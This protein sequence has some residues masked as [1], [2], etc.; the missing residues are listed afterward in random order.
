MQGRRKSQRGLTLVEA[1]VATALT[2]LLFLGALNLYVAAAQLA[3]STAA[4]CYAVTDGANAVQHI[5]RDA[6]EARRLA[7]PDESG[8]QPPGNMPLSAFQTADGSAVIS[9]GV[10]LV[11]PAT[12]A[13]SVQSRSSGALAV[14]PL[15]YDRTQEAEPGTLWIYRSDAD[16]TPDAAAG[17]YLWLSG[18]ERGQ[19]VNQA[20]ISSLSPALPNAVKFARPQASAATLPFQLQISLVSSA[21]SPL[22]QAQTSEIAATASETTVVGKCALLRDHEMNLDYEPNPTAI[23][24]AVNSPTWRSD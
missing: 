17:A 14:S 22:R 5:V 1:T 7:L 4:S 20:L 11:F 13:A 6:E 21:Y 18:I 8:W 10:Q 16:G 23:Y 9:T 3:V 15:P 19:A 12:A 2:M 24:G